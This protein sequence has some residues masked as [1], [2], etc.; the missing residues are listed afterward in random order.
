MNTYKFVIDNVL[1]V[2]VGKKCVSYW[3]W[4]QVNK[5][6]LLYTICYDSGYFNIKVY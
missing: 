2:E 6:E 1:R 5:H 3:K 4:D